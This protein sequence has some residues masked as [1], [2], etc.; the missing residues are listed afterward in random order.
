MRSRI[1][2]RNVSLSRYPFTLNAVSKSHVPETPTHTGHMRN[3]SALFI[4]PTS[5]DTAKIEKIVSMVAMDLEEKNYSAKRYHCNASPEAH[6]EFFFIL[7]L[8]NLPEKGF[9]ACDEEDD[10]ERRDKEEVVVEEGSEA[11]R[12]GCA[13]MQESQ[14]HEVGPTRAG[15]FAETHKYAQ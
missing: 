1:I 11:G 4:S 7:P 3:G 10:D 8:F 14:D 9:V 2:G 6:C 15:E 13:I 5:A 12:E